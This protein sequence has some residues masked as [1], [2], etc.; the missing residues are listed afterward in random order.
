MATGRVARTR[1]T[2][3]REGFEAERMSAII[4]GRCT[5]HPFEVAENCCRNCGYDYCSECLVYAFGPKKPPF[6][7]ACALAAAGVR[8]NAANRPVMSRREMRRRDKERKKARRAAEAPVG[9]GVGADLDWSVPEGSSSA[10]DWAD[11][12]DEDA[13]GVVSF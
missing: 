12:V 6:C 7:V 10:F 3:A 5:K 4:E 2:V 13:D 11:K 8:S 1:L 9:A